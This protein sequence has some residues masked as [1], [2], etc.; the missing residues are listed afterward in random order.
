MHKRVA[1][2]CIDTYSDVPHVFDADDVATTVREGGVSV[3]DDR[4]NVI[5]VTGIRN[6]D[7]PSSNYTRYAHG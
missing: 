5:T 4:T 3:W 2:L 6:P 1:R 7:L